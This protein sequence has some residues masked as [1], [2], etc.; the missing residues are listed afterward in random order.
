[1]IDHFD[2]SPVEARVSDLNETFADPG[3]K[4]MLTSLG[5]GGREEARTPAGLRFW[6]GSYDVPALTTLAASHHP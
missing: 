4:G 1:M 2:S 5:E 6:A 3:V